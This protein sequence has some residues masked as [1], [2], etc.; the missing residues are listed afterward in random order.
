LALLAG[1]GDIAVHDGSFRS[2][3]F[4]YGI[5]ARALI[6]APLLILAEVVTG[7]RVSILACRFE[8]L[9][10]LSK[11]DLPHFDKVVLSTLR[12]RN[13]RGMELTVF[14]IGLLMAGT[15]AYFIPIPLLPAWSFRAGAESYSRSLAG[16][17]LVLVSTPILTL[18]IVGWFCRL[19]LWT[20]FLILVSRLKLRILVP[21]PDGA[22]GLQ[23]LGL[24]LHSYSAV[25]FALG[26]ILA[27]TMAN[28]V[29]HAGASIGDFEYIIAGFTVFAVVVFTSPLLAFNWM[30]LQ[31]R[32][33]GIALYGA[34]AHSVGREFERTWLN[35]PTQLR[36]DPLGR[37]DFSATTDLYSIVSNA[38]RMKIVPFSR[39]NLTVLAA[40]SLM[41]FLP[42]ALMSLPVEHVASYVGKLLF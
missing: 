29:A 26:T 18:L 16:W 20:R 36:H 19:A 40:G 10:I 22:G 27:G 23:F 13:S 5:H 32:R 2:F 3:L 28:R 37:Q 30:L 6:A 42:V 8:A 12:L 1:I 33:R 15:L 35:P 17:W 11:E 39:K 24:S 41:P 21:H 9:G 4:D 31:A 34:L 25:A 38:H 14:A 7:Q